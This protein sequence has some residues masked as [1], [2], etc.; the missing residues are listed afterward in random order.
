MIN[1]DIRLFIK[2]FLLFCLVLIGMSLLLFDSALKLFYLKIFPLQFAIVALVTF[3]SHLRLMKSFDQNIRNFSTT[4]L[5]TMSVKLFIYMAFILVCLVIDRSQ[6]VNF[7]L[8]FLSLY[9][10]FT[11][12]EV[13]QISDFLKKNKKS[14][15]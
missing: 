15:N 2:K 4:F 9:L 7:V 8:T 14:S 3:L 10:C 12:F 11:T 5:A 13:I 1:K 6:A